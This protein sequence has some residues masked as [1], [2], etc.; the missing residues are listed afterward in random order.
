MPIKLI[1]FLLLLCNTGFAQNNNQ[2]SPTQFDTFINQPQIVWAAYANVSLSYE[3]VILNKILLERFSKKEIK[4]AL[5]IESGLPEA[6]AIRFLSKKSIDSI[7]YFPI[8]SSV[9]LFDS[10][11]NMIS[12]KT[13]TRQPVFDTSVK[14]TTVTTQIFY[15]ENGKLS[16]YIPWVSPVI[17]PV[18]TSTGIF[19]GNTACFSTCFNFLYNSTVSGKDKIIFLGHTNHKLFLDSAATDGKLKELYGRNIVETLWPY[20]MA[21]RFALYLTDDNKKI[22]AGDIDMELSKKINEAVPISVYDENGNAISKSYRTPFSPKRI[23]CIEIIQDWYYDYTKNIVVNKIKD[24]YLYAKKWD[25]K[26]GNNPA[27]PILKI[28]FN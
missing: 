3:P 18:T 10:E 25:N 9:N 14:S 24:A 16:S 21:N 19:L 1:P 27:I 26:G 28:V 11:G 12:S 17:L 13:I 2:P 5:P 7:L 23:T 8:Q 6:N 22:K 20:I 4:A 15:I